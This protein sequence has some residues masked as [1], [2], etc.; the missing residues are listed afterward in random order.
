MTRTNQSGTQAYNPYLPG[1]EYIPDAEPHTFSGRVYVFGSHDRAQ[2]TNY[3]QN[4]YVSWSAPEDDLAN[5]R[6]EGVIFAKTDD[7]REDV[8][9]Y[10]P[11]VVRGLDGRY[12]LYYSTANTSFISVAVCDEP[13]GHYQ[14]LGD[15][16]HANGDVLGL[17]EGDYFAFDPGVL[18]DDDCRV[19]LYAGS[20]QKS[21]ERYGHPLGLFVAELE[22]DMVTLKS[23]PR[24]LMEADWDHSKPNFWE[25]PSIRHIGELYY[26]VYPTTDFAG[27]G[28]ATSRY[29]DRDFEFRGAIH[30]ASDIRPGGRTMD[31]GAY[32]LGNSHG[33]I[34]EA[35]GQWYVFDHRTTNDTLF[36]RQGVAEP[37][38]IG[39]DGTIAPVEA[40]SCGL[41][42]GPLRGEGTYPTHIACNL[43]AGAG[44]DR[45][46]SKLS[47]YVTQD[48]S[49]YDP[50]AGGPKPVPYVTNIRDG[51][52]V[53]YKH[54]SIDAPA[55]LVLVVRGAA[56]G[57]LSVGTNPREGT[58]A[59]LDLE[60]SEW[61]S[62]RVP[63]DSTGERLALYICFEGEGSFDLKEF[64]FVH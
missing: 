24:L 43:Y 60:S 25:G 7:P 54:F 51:A 45:T 26:L 36:S 63:L 44:F 13:A 31:N 14:Y 40:T 20:G 28:Y 16:A 39:P 59:V 3:C 10:A 49:D 8:I 38:E 17:R 62:V 23:E 46:Q 41:N 18:V 33:G 27:L 11:D 4:D 55:E 15:V 19:W 52:V 6:Y 64:E 53:G 34:V 58:C 22:P 29:P 2:G 21:N 50:S 35:C 57:V 42:G 1:W 47:P 5:W 61:T 9:L 32:P 48:E 30:S 12:Y 37:I 56:Q